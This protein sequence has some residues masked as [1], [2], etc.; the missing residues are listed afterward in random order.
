[1][2][3]HCHITTGRSLDTVMEINIVFWNV[4]TEE[5]N[6]WTFDLLWNISFICWHHWLKFANS[7]QQAS[8]RVCF[9]VYDSL[10]C[11]LNSRVITSVGTFRQSVILIS[12]HQVAIE[13]ITNHFNLTF[14]YVGSPPTDVRGRATEM[15][16]LIC[17]LTNRSASSLFRGGARG[18][19]LPSNWRQQQKA[20]ISIS[21]Q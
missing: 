16:W 15:K 8:L 19:N 21:Q 2:D 17:L 12:Y 6:C 3:S 4:R 13:V 20:L 7:H 14:Y 11:L 10:I 5:E 9:S 1:M 18:E